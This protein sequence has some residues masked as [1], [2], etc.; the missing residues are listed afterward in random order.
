MGALPQKPTIMRPRLSPREQWFYERIG[1][2]IYR[3]NNGCP[4]LPCRK[5]Y[6]EGLLISDHLQAAYLYD[7]ECD[8][9]RDDRQV[10]YFDTKEEA[11]AFE[12]GFC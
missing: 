6:E 3:N 4:C 8:F 12:N 7:I 5:V 2:I 9:S 1:K 10:R 11:L